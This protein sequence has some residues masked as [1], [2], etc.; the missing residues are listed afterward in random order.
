MPVDPW[1]EDEAKPPRQP[2][3]GCLVAV[4]IASA[5]SIIALVLVL[6]V[7]VATFTS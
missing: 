5:T 2:G 6:K 4:V 1:S 3:W 7:I